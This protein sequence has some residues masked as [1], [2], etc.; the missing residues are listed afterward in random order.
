MIPI[1]G[2]PKF[3]LVM[4]EPQISDLAN[5]I[6]FVRNSRIKNILDLSEVAI[7]GG[8]DYNDMHQIR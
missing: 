6:N 7:I 8:I 5:L 4:C 3:M 1:R 2:D